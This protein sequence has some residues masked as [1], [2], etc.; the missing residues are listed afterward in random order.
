MGADVAPGVPDVHLQRARKSVLSGSGYEGGEKVTVGASR[1]GR[2]WSH[3]R[4]RVDQLA[5]WC[6]KMG[7]TLL[8]ETVNPDEVLKGTLETKT[9]AERPAAMPIMVDWPEEMYKMPESIWSIMVD[10]QERLFSELIIDV[11]DPALNG[12]L[13]FAIHL[14]LSESSWRL[15]SSK[16]MTVPIID[17][18]SA[19]ISGYS[20]VTVAQKRKASQTFS[21]ATR[22]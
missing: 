8:D 6:K 22:R 4:D 21:M 3:R 18:S 16:K 11:V 7:A 20:C 19:E 12:S 15:N 5:A 14:T 2:I 17:S 10:G 9:L 1:K 13:R